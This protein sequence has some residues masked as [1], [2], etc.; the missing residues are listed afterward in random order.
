MR[1][2]RQKT[3]LAIHAL[4]LE[5]WADTWIDV[6]QKTPVRP[7]ETVRYSVSGVGDILPVTFRV[8]DA[9]GAIVYEEGVRSN[10]AGNAWVNTVAPITEGSYTLEAT[11]PRWGWWGAWPTNTLVY[12]YSVSRQATQPT[13]TPKPPTW[14]EGIT[15]EFKTVVWVVVIGLVAYAVITGRK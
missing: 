7:G 4:R 2:Q 5:R 8:R 13:P 3:H 15:G 6:P 12:E 1:K 14:W 10:L 11:G 9:A